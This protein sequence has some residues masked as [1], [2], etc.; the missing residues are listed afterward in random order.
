MERHCSHFSKLRNHPI[1]RTT[2]TKTA[3]ENKI[4]I[5][6]INQTL[7]DARVVEGILRMVGLIALKK[8]R[9]N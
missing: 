1:L 9:R 4:K 3:L 6:R 5:T 2:T 8:S 7:R